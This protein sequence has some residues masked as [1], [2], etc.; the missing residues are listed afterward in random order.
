MAGLGPRWWPVADP[1]RGQHLG[2]EWCHWGRQEAALRAMVSARSE[3]FAKAL[4]R[5]TFCLTYYWYRTRLH[6]ASGRQIYFRTDPSGLTYIRRG[7]FLIT[8]GNIYNV[9]Y[10]NPTRTL[11]SRGSEVR[12][13]PVSL[14]RSHPLVTAVKSR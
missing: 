9:F 6:E 8:G 13:R 7:N 10:F 14:R 1:G 2:H 3:R 4:L 11:Q 5:S 12:P